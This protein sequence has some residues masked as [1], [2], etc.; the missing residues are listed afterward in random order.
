MYI[1]DED[2]LQ[3]MDVLEVSRL[4]DELEEGDN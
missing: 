2:N 1:F 3:G 4:L